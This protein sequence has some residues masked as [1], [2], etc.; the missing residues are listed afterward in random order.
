MK[1]SQKG[2]LKGICTK[3]IRYR[4]CILEVL[5]FAKYCEKTHGDD[6]ILNINIFHFIT[7]LTSSYAAFC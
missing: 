3:V 5:A 2:I 4:G 1:V 6:Q 7:R